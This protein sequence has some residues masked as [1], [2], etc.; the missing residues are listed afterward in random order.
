MYIGLHTKY[1]LFLSDINE[2]NFLNRF[3][4][5]TRIS[6]FTKSHPAGAELIHADRQ[7]DMTKLLVAFRYFAKPP[8]NA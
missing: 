3:S 8:E 5:K 4:K 7:T 6:N 2:K 1:P